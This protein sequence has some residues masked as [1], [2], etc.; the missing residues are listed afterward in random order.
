VDTKA[1]ILRS[2]PVFAA[3]KDSS[4]AGVIAALQ[5]AGFDKSL[6]LDLVEFLPLAFA[7]ASLEGRG[8]QFAEYYVRI[9]GQKR[10]RARK[11]LIEQPV[12]REALGLVLDVKRQGTD[13][14][15]SIASRSPELPAIN[16]ALQGGSRPEQVRLPP[17]ALVWSDDREEPSKPARAKPAQPKRAKAWW[18][19]WK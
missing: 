5:R 15:M 17:P 2:V 8:V 6:A 12:Y 10:E 7:R 13:V 9:D 4:R 18:Q 19:F 16:Q 14:F 3:N 1:E 11:K